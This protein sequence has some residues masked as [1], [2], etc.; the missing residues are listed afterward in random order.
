MSIFSKL[1]GGGGGD[2]APPARTETVEHKGFRIFAKPVKET[3]GHRVAARIEKEVDGETRT[4][5][6]IRA[7][8]CSDPNE[9][10]DLSVLKARQMIDEQGERI[11][12]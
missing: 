8:V 5:E 12:R 4:H 3:G 9:A 10:V 6:M 7:D 11:F 1:F 2:K